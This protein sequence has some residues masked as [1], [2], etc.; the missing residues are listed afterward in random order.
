[1][2]SL[3]VIKATAVF[4]LNNSAIGNNYKQTIYFNIMGNVKILLIESYYI[5][6]RKGYKMLSCKGTIQF[7]L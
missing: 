5:I 2:N 7:R 6:L 4:S 1:M 3:Q